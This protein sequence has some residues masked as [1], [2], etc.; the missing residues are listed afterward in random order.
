MFTSQDYKAVVNNSTQ[1][2]SHIQQ[3]TAIPTKSYNKITYSIRPNEYITVTEDGA[4]IWKEAVLK[5]DGV[6]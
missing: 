4:V 5:T 6:W 2:G 1:P 3:L